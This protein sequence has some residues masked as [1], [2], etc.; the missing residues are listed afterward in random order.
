M[1]R[2]AVRRT[3]EAKKSMKTIAQQCKMDE[4]TV[5]FLHRETW[6]MLRAAGDFFNVSGPRC[7]VREGMDW[8]GGGTLLVA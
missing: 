3:A 7:L 5:E 8:V 6:S 2:D 1:G 4:D